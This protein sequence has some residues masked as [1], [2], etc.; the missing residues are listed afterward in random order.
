MNQLKSFLDRKVREYNQP[1]FIASDPVSVPHL[2]SKKQDIEISGLFAALFA[3]GNRTA[4]I[5][6]SRRL[7]ELMDMSPH[8][9]IM[10]CD[11]QD[12]RRLEGFCH[13]TF[14]TTDLLYFIEF[15]RYHYNQWPSL[16]D[17]FV[18]GIAG[19]SA[20]RKPNSSSPENDPALGSGPSKGAIPKRN[21]LR[22]LD[23]DNVRG[24]VEARQKR[25]TSGSKRDGSVVREFTRAKEAHNS[26]DRRPGKIT[27]GILDV[28]TDSPPVFME[29][30]LNRFRDY[31]FSLEDAPLRTRKHIA[32]PL[33]N[34]SCKR[35][36]M[37]LRWMVRK[38]NRGVDFGLWQKISPAQLICPIDLHVLRVA[39]RFKLIDGKKADWEAATALTRQLSAFD[40]ADPVKYDFALFG[41][42]VVEK[43]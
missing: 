41:L 9:F 6:K 39:Q 13:R 20:N 29:N 3:W 36:N 5:N 32:S 37:Y 25:T 16:E 17:A 1:L 2:F 21:G 35:L 27:G 38:D 19:V 28:M 8:D 30:A 14:N 33:K 24:I 11:E 22:A 4:I 23:T 10:G 31:F 40:P 18:K 12:L 7:M 15:L 42:G 34:S 26:T 43:F